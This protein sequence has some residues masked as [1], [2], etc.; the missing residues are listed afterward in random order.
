[1]SIKYKKIFEGAFIERPNRFIAKVLLNGDT[2]TVHVKNTGRCRELLVSG[3]KVYLSEADNPCRKTRFDLVAVEKRCDDGRM[4]LINMDSQIPNAA[5]YEWIAKSKVFSA[6]A[7]IR[8]EVTYGDSRFDLS[9]ED[10][11]NV[12]FIEVKGVTLERNGIAMFPD[13]PTE[14]GTK[15]LRGLVSAVNNGYNAMVLFV[16]Q[17]KGVHEFTPNYA[18]DPVFSETLHEAVSEGVRVM[19]VDCNVTHDSIEIDNEVPIRL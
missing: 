6:N 4:I 19:A 13:A 15:H 11:G 16:I 1:M 2:V 7:V 12:T 9:V 8:R 10:E 18:T 3:C 17:M 14:R 5:V